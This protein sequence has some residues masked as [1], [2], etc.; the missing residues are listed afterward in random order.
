VDVVELTFDLGDHEVARSYRQTI[1]IMT[2]ESTRLPVFRLEPRVSTRRV[3]S[4]AGEARIVLRRQTGECLKT[5][6]QGV[7]GAPDPLHEDY[8][9]T[10]GYTPAQRRLIECSAHSPLPPISESVEAEGQIRQL[11][12]QPLR[13]FFYD[14]KGWHLESS[15]Y[16]LAVWRSGGF[17]AP[18]ELGEYLLSAVEIADHV[19]AA[20]KR[21]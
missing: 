21:A 6:N 14:T 10:S 2:L 11:F 8:E 9:L 18:E 7:L 3:P 1:V 13:R 17:A 20:W 19:I 12:H 5:A 4:C 15:G 16:H